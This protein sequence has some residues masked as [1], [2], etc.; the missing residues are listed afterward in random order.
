[1]RAHGKIAAGAL[2]ALIWAPWAAAST[3][4][5][6]RADF[7][8]DGK[9]DRMA[10]ETTA[11]GWRLVAEVGARR[12]VLEDQPGSPDGFYLKLKPAGRYGAVRVRHAAVDF[13]REEAGDQ[14]LYW[15]GRRWAR[16]QL[17]D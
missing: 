15:T 9:A 5:E 4:A 13:G 17:G 2:A 8:G 14:I 3:F 11:R 10:I 12:T 1:M 16:V 6:V 7:D